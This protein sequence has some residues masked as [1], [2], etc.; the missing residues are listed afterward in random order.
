MTEAKENNR[1]VYGNDAVLVSDDGWCE[2]WKYENDCGEAVITGYNVLP[3]VSLA[4]N[5]IHLSSGQIERTVPDKI[6][7]IN[8][9][10]EGRI[11]CELNDEFFY[12]APGDFSIAR[13]MSTGR[14]SYFPLSHYHGITILIDTEHAPKCLSCL[15]ADVDVN[16]DELSRK[17]CGNDGCYIARSKPYIAHIFSELYS[18][19]E[20]IQKGYFKVKILELLLYLSG[21]EPAN[22]CVERSAYSQ[23]Q[24][25]LAKSVCQY[26]TE[27]M[28]DRIT[29]AQLSDIF[30]ISGTQIKNSFKGVYGV[31]VYAYIRTQKMHSA[32]LMLRHTKRSVIDIAGSFG[33]DN[34]SKFASA[35]KNVIGMTPNEYRNADIPD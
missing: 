34:A 30:H 6:L 3:G 27:H 23:N 12:L 29:L 26:L 20:S 22:E 24:T 10:R 32:A 13:K 25:D 1:Y 16:P 7:E 2:V 5:D 18:V 31:S 8:H 4:Y 28:D 33:Y 15:L 11:E 17:F 9:C 21:M 14:L 35:F 19:P